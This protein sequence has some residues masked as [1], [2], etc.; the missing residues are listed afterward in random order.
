MVSLRLRARFYR[1]CFRRGGW[2][3]SG[4]NT[5]PPSPQAPPKQSAPDCGALSGLV[6]PNR[7]IAVSTPPRN[8]A[9]RRP[10]RAVILLGRRP[11]YQVSLA[12]L[13]PPRPPGKNA[14]R[15][16]TR[17]APATS[18]SPPA[19]YLT[20]QRVSVPGSEPSARSVG[21]SSVAP[22]TQPAKSKAT[23]WPSMPSVP[24]PG[25]RSAC[26]SDRQ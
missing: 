2:L 17:E 23:G 10:V 1:N 14:G 13:Q 21:R 6:S 11:I 20:C 25:S 3:S 9:A 15:K 5:R 8:A 7:H 24:N 18:E 22:F 26:H 12:P 16:S 19:S 4:S